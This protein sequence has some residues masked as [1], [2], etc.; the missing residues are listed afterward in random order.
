MGAGHPIAAPVLRKGA[1]ERP[2]PDLFPSS[3]ALLRAEA[4][5]AFLREAVQ[6][7]ALRTAHKA[8]HRWAVDVDPLGI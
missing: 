3:L 7:Q 4:A 5:A 1:F 2:V 6:L 8:V